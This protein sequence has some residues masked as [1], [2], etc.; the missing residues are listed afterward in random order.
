MVNLLGI[1]NVTRDSFSDGGAYLDPAAALAH[2]RRLVADGA[3]FVDIGAESSQ[4]DAHDVPP[5]E[6]LERLTPLVRTL[7]QEGVR[8]SIDTHRPDVMRAMLALGVDVINDI[9]ALRDPAAVELL[10]HHTARVILMHSA[11]G[12][13]ARRD[14]AGDEGIVARILTFF[15]ARITALTAAGIARERLILDPGMGLF[16]SSDPADSLRV[17][18]GLDRLRS[19]GLPLCVCTSRKSFLGAIAGGAGPARPLRERGAATLASEIYAVQHGVGYI[20][21]HD[22]RALRDALAVLQQIEATPE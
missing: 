18:R 12:A 2:A 17:L 13:R 4:P 16:L 20:R 11:T 15:E 6:Q 10:G 9:T 21:T 5:A 14:L 1:L 8:I 7:K 19:L 3:D 22:V